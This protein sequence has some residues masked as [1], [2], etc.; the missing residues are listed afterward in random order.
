MKD[1]QANAAQS[2]K[3]ASDARCRPWRHRIV[4]GMLGVVLG[5]TAVGTLSHA[6]FGPG[7]GPFGHGPLAAS[8]PEAS[9]ARR[10]WVGFAIERMLTK[11]DA[12]DAQKAEVRAI[13]EPLA[14]ELQPVRETFVANRE[15]M[16]RVLLAPAVDRT[17]LEALR[18]EQMDQADTVSRTLASTLADV[19]DVL[20]PEQRSELASRIAE[21]RQ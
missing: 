5:A 11:V 19:A 12:S 16:M 8:G 18:S 6:G 13:L 2:P 21:R 10:A 17:E 14:A 7:W 15:S 3:T 4:A 1:N 20:T 9:E